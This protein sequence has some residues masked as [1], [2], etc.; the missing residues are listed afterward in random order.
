MLALTRK[1]KPYSVSDYSF[2]TRHR[3]YYRR[4]GLRDFTFSTSQI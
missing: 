2:C 1:I 4:K 3:G